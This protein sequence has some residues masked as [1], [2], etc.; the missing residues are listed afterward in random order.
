M[1][2]F[3]SKP[4]TD[5]DKKKYTFGMSASISFLS[6]LMKICKKKPDQVL[7][8]DDLKRLNNT[9]Y[10]LTLEKEIS[11]DSPGAPC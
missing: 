10:R 8:N 9:S 6:E 1:L 11:I 7:T 2:D 4:N 5:N 3:S